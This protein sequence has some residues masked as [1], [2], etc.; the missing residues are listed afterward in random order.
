MTTTATASRSYVLGDSHNERRRLQHQAGL[1]GGFTRHVFEQAGIVPGMTVLDVGCGAGDVSLL[2]AD[3]V[4]PDGHVIGLDRNPD[5]VGMAEERT[6]SAG[7]ANVRYVVGD[8]HDP[9]IDV[10]LDLD[11]AVGRLVLMYS[12]DIVAALRTISERVAPGGILAFQEADFTWFAHSI[13]SLPLM[14]EVHDWVSGAFAAGGSDPNIGFRLAQH[15][16]AA[17]LP[18]PQLHFDTAMGGGP[19]HGGYQLAEA[20]V[21]S[22]L[23]AIEAAG[24][25]TASEIEVDTIADRL[26]D[27]TIAADATITTISLV[28]AWSRRPGTPT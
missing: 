6:A 14:T 23:P 2:L 24:I 16:V 19:D 7:V 17:G 3:M 10:G 13:P 22:L 11:A 20:T 5:I 27:A 26:R 25:A 21:R 8:L 1:V 18:R 4:G 12:P 28:A 15:F 9:H